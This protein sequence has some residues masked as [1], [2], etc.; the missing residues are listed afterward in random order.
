VWWQGF[1]NVVVFNFGEE[2]EVED[3]SKV[4]GQ[5]RIIRKILEKS[6]ELKG[7]QIA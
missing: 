3:R 5:L 4:A 2:K 1:E 7:V 6:R